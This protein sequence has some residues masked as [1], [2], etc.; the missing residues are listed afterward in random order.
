MYKAGQKN[1]PVILY[2]A[3]YRGGRNFCALAVEN[4]HVEAFCDRDAESIPLYYGCEVYTMEQAVQQFGHLP[5]ILC[6]DDAESRETVYTMLQEKKIEVYKD[7]QS[8]YTGEND[9]DI[10]TIC[11][12]DKATFQVAPSFWDKK[13][14]VTAFSFGIGFDFS[15]ERE[16]A[17]KYNV[18][19]FAFDPSPEVV[20]SMKEEKLPDNLKYYPYGLSDKDEKK[21]FYLPS[22]GQDYSEYFASWTGKNTVELQVYRLKTLMD[23]FG[24]SKLDLLK[25]DVEGSEFL[26]MPEILDSGVQFDQLCIETHARIFPNSVEVMRNFKK[27]MLQHGYALISNGLEEQT[28]IRKDK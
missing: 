24:C 12:G 21:T 16:L 13:E 9:A 27:M 7:I 25:M 17:E 4:V 11:C 2:G 10:K 1:Q 22:S 5:F 3:G 23:M 19:V 26:A 20:R 6:L 28:Y 15:F 18:N 14:R 8:Y